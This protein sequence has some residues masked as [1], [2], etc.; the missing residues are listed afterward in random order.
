MVSG[1]L[2][3]SAL[4]PVARSSPAG[5]LLNPKFQHLLLLEYNKIDALVWGY[6][7]QHNAVVGPFDLHAIRQVK[8]QSPLS[9]DNSVTGEAT[10]SIAM[11]SVTAPGAV[12]L[13]RNIDVVNGVPG[14]AVT[15]DQL[16]ATND[17]ITAATAGGLT[18]LMGTAPIVVSG[19]GSVRD[20]KVLEATTAATGVVRLADDPAVA[21]GASDR[22]TTAAQLKALGSQVTPYVQDTLPAP[23]PP[24][25]KEIPGR[26]WFDT[27]NLVLRIWDPDAQAWVT[28]VDN[29]PQNNSSFVFASNAPITVTSVGAFPATVTIGF[30]V[31]ALATLP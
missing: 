4:A 10:L 21:A 26:L 20:V 23:V 11:A 1:A 7:Q 8:A 16:K 14:L 12:Q 19:L 5:P 29:S 28:L 2:R 6:D 25:Q 17:A 3:R 18:G 30:D 15:S 31:T 27:A 24:P 13:A 9:V 22:V